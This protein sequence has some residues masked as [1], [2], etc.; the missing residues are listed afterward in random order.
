MVGTKES[1]LPRTEE[2]A[3]TPTHTPE[4]LAEAA[5]KS[6]S[7]VQGLPAG[8]KRGEHLAKAKQDAN[9]PASRVAKARSS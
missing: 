1:K 7:T 3:R 6:R 8:P 9:F 5:R 2:Q 4:G